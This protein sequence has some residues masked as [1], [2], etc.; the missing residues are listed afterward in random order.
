MDNISAN[1]SGVDTFNFVSLI[2][3][4]VRTSLNVY[5]NSRNVTGDSQRASLL[6][7]RHKDNFNHMES[8]HEAPTAVT[9]AT[10]YVERAVTFPSHDELNVSSK[11]GFFH[12]YFRPFVMISLDFF[13]FF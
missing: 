10:I 4:D 5:E 12:F 2:K 1:P 7:Q 13:F 3:I 11:P 8:R 9:R 6:P